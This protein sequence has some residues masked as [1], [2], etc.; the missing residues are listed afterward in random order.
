M[1]VKTTES[2][3][4]ELRWRD[5]LYDITEGAEEMQIGRAHV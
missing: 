3:V 5:L 2:L 4:D 1:E